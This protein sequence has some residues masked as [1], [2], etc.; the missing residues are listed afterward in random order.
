MGSWSIA[1]FPVCKLLKVEDVEK[2][3]AALQKYLDSMRVLLGEIYRLVLTASTTGSM[4]RYA[5]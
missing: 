2:H 4:Y 1:T 5:L 3:I